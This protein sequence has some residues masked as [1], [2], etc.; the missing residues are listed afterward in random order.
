M[1][2]EPFLRGHLDF[3]PAADRVLLP[4]RGPTSSG[5][6]SSIDRP[7]S[8]AVVAALTRSPRQAIGDVTAIHASANFSDPRRHASLR[9]FT[10][11]DA[12]SQQPRTR[13]SHRSR[14]A[15]SVQI[16]VCRERR[17]PITN[18]MT[19]GT[20]RGARNF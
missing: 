6:T 19:M 13:S 16:P 9:R 5:F 20:Y 14:T 15:R 8:A 10:S 1:T 2:R 7:C 18:I 4:N 12:V 3:S 17:Q 11:P